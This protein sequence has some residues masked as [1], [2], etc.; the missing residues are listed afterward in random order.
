MDLIF[1][2][3]WEGFII[4]GIA[5]VIWIISSLAGANKMLLQIRT[6]GLKTWGWATSLRFQTS[7]GFFKKP[8]NVGPNL[9]LFLLL[10]LMLNLL[11]PK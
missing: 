9:I 1:A 4:P 6:P 2:V 5:F 8:S 11:Q 7:S 10:L 3:G